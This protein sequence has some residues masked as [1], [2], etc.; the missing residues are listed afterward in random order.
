M[1]KSIR[2]RRLAGQERCKR[3][4]VWVTWRLRGLF[5]REG[6]VGGEV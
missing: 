6:D 3:R 1:C 2:K 4:G 5:A